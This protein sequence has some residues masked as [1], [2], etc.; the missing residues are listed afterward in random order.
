[1]SSNVYLFFYSNCM[2]D[3]NINIF[4]NFFR[5]Y[6]NLKIISK[7]EHAFPGITVSGEI[8]YQNFMFNLIEKPMAEGKKLFFSVSR[9]PQG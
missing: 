4:N 7:A 5:F 2:Y 1:M 8:L 3:C 6:L 9:L